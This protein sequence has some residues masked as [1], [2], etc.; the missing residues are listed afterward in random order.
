VLLGSVF[1]DA[2][3]L[4]DGFLAV[5]HVDAA[6]SGCNFGMT[7]KTGYTAVL[8]EAKIFLNNVLDKTPFVDNLVLQ[9]SDDG[10]TWTDVYTFG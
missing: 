5:D 6:S 9:G 7:F 8:D 2:A 10:A 4:T 3:A 1:P